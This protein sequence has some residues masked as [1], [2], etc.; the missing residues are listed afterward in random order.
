MCGIDNRRWMYTY[1][2]ARTCKRYRTN[3]YSVAATREI[4][5]VWTRPSLTVGTR[6]LEKGQDQRVNSR[7]DYD[8]IKEYNRRTYLFNRQQLHRNGTERQMCASKPD[9]A[10]LK[11]RQ[12]TSGPIRGSR[13]IFSRIMWKTHRILLEEDREAAPAHS[14]TAHVNERRGRAPVAEWLAISIF[15][16][17]WERSRRSRRPT[18]RGGLTAAV[19]RATCAHLPV[20]S[21]PLHQEPDG[22][23][24][25]RPTKDVPRMFAPPPAWTRVPGKRDPCSVGSKHLT[26]APKPSIRQLINDTPPTQWSA[27]FS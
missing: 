6:L 1:G 8:T 11:N 22:T 7:K 2:H 27:S 15:D 3:I 16:S 18:R 24:K 23:P 14:L 12:K 4:A 9:A 5:T 25:Q 20:P 19:A 10:L 26:H 17:L 21:P 13:E